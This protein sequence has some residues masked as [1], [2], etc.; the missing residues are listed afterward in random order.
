MESLSLGNIFL[1]F[2]FS[3]ILFSI[4]V[5]LMYGFISPDLIFPC[6]LILLV[7]G[8]ILMTLLSLFPII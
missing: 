8:Q 3:F 2:I 5:I 7:F 6:Q 4:P 1:L